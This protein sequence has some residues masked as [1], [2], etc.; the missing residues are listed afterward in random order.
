MNARAFLSAKL[1]ALVAL[2]MRGEK[3]PN[4]DVAEYFSRRF[5]AGPDHSGLSRTHKRNR[6]ALLAASRRRAQR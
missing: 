2:S 5:V 6:R 4:A 3:A 1:A